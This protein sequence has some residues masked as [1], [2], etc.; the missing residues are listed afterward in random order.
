MCE[1]KKGQVVKIYEDPISC[2]KCEGYA[3]L[4]S[5]LKS[6]SIN[7]CEYWGVRFLLDFITVYRHINIK[8]H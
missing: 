2:T 3:T 1:L 7:G 4:I 8:N 5:F 6:D